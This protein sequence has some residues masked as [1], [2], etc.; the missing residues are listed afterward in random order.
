MTEPGVEDIVIDPACGA[1]S[2]LVEAARTLTDA[3]PAV[4][5]SLHGVDKDA[6]LVRLARLRLALEFGESADLHCAD[7]LAWSGNGFDASDT[8]RNTGAYTLV[9]TNPPFGSRIVAARE[10]VRNQFVLARKWAFDRKK[11]R[12]AMSTEFQNNPAP[13]VL[14]VER[15]LSLLA[16]DG[17]LGMV[18][19]ESVLSSPSHRYVVQHVLEN[20]TVIAVVGM[21]ESLFKTSGKGGT[22]TKVCLLVLKKGP[23][24]RGHRIFMAEA[25]WCGHDSRGREIP[26]DDLPGVEEQ[27]DLFKARR[28]LRASRLGFVVAM[29]DIKDMVLAPRYY[30]PEPRNALAKLAKTHELVPMRTL[31]S[32]GH[33]SI[34]TGDEPGKLIYGTGDVPF[35]RTSDLSNWEVKI[36]PKHCVSEEYYQQVARRQDVREG[37]VLM[38]RDGTYLIGTCALITRYDVRICYQS[39]IYKIRAHHGAPLDCYLLLALLSSDP[40]V[41]QIRA[42]SFT[43]DIIDSLGDRIQEIVL[44]IPKS[45]EKKRDISDLVRKVIQDRIEARELARQARDLVVS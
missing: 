45:S 37:D 28:S 16:P 30:N 17:R 24:P 15:C 8:R 43:Q 29:R 9:L 35:V 4:K 44:P 2:F 26:R 42:L 10:D 13:Q 40:V 14:F 21:P 27:F 31:I 1:G 5:R 3:N 33:V 32:E 19:P 23:P 38:V 36:D 18:L 22:H 20:A 6:Y 11:S 41:S 34:A 12:F 25:K 7:S 39:H